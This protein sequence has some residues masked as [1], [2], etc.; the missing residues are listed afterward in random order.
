LAV[1]DSSA[2]TAATQ[3][4]PPPRVAEPHPIPNA[5]GEALV[6]MAAE[7]DR[8]K[9]AW[10]ADYMRNGV[11]ERSAAEKELAD[12]QSQYARDVQQKKSE[13]ADVE[14]E[15][16][17]QAEQA[18]RDSAAAR[19][20]F[21]SQEQERSAKL[22]LDYDAWLLARGR[23]AVTIVKGL[24]EREHAAIG[25]FSDTEAPDRIF[26]FWTAEE[27]GAPE[28]NIAAKTGV[29]VQQPDARFFPHFRSNIFLYDPEGQILVHTM[30]S[31]VERHSS[32]TAELDERKVAD[33]SELANWDA[34]H[35]AGPVR[36][37]GAQESA[38]K[39]RDA[40]IGRLSQAKL[41]I[42]ESERALDPSRANDA[43]GQSPKGREW[44]ERI[45]A[46]KKALNLAA[47][48]P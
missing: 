19:K 22:K 37:S 40:A 3:V 11:A 24:R 8:E 41:R 5:P 27:A 17:R 20:T 6:A 7:R 12:A 9:A 42:A 32:L 39:A 28:I 10:I 45:R 21:M 31:I 16:A 48:S 18:A 26:E 15:V 29:T 4:E 34:R 38:L 30:E 44:A 43:F 1:G 47:A 23:E 35:P 14:D 36:L 13:L 2:E 33:E 25:V 46:A